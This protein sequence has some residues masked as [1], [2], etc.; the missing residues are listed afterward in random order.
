M[1]GP[2]RTDPAA[3]FV[4]G[5]AWSRS[6]TAHRIDD[7]LARVPADDP[8]KA[9]L[10]ARARAHSRDCGCAMSGAFLGVALLLTLVYVAATVD[11]SIRTALASAMFVLLATLLGKLT[12]LLLAWVKLAVLHRSLSRKLLRT[13]SGHV[14]VH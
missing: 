11:L 5:F 7:L 3:S 2:S 6:R 13:T 14:Y 1:V 10:E 12:G 8:E 4:Q 9:A